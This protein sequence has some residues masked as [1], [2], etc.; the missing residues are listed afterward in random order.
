VDEQ[1]QAPR[2]PVGGDTAAPQGGLQAPGSV[3]LAK[4][5]DRRSP[6]AY[7]YEDKL[8]IYFR[9]GPVL[10]VSTG[11]APEEPEGEAARQRASG[12][13]GPNDPDVIQGR[14]AYKEERPPRRTPAQ[15]ELLVAED[16][17][18]AARRNLPPRDRWPRVVLRFAPERELLLSGMISG[19]S[20]LAEKPAVIDVPSG[21]GHVVLFAN[22]P[23]WR[24]ETMGSF[25]LLFN[26][27]LNYRHLHA[28]RPPASPPARQ[29]ARVAGAEA[30]APGP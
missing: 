18:D 27:A 22:N 9:Q 8:P 4:F 13:G 25:F 23:M 1:R 26:A 12:R 29:P 7:G 14:D 20:A 24:D 16:Q 19:G 17:E 6:I 10:K 21:E 3:L 5:D 30:A 11:Y 15:K 2:S 28:G